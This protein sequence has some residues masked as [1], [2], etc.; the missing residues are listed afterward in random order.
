[1]AAHPLTQ[2]VTSGPPGY[3]DGRV[4]DWFAPVFQTETLNGLKLSTWGCLV[5]LVSS[6]GYSCTWSP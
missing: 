1:M 4:S 5:S 2:F 6:P 3:L